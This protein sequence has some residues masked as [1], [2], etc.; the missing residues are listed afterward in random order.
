MRSMALS[1]RDP[2]KPRR[3]QAPNPSDGRGKNARCL[4]EKRPEDKSLL[5]KIR[6]RVLVD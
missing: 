6:V 3:F 4:V 1:R 5:R 2:R